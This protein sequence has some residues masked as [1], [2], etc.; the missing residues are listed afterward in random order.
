MGLDY[1]IKLRDVKFTKFYV[2][3]FMCK[4][5]AIQGYLYSILILLN[6]DNINDTGGNCLLTCFLNRKLCVGVSP[7]ITSESGRAFFLGYMIMFH[8]YARSNAGPRKCCHKLV[9]FNGNAKSNI[10]PSF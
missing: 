6:V 3:L 8:F 2:Y 5:F 7:R 10:Y 4:L 1:L 9:Y